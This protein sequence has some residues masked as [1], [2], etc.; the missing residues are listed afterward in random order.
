MPNIKRYKVL[1]RLMNRG[2]FGNGDRNSLDTGK[3]DRNSFDTG[4]G[5]RNS[6]DIDKG[7]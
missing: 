5:D 7:K 6:L 4:K 3:G 2:I 1:L